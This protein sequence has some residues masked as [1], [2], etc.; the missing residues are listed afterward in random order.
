MLKVLNRNRKPGWD[1][2]PIEGYD[3]SQSAKLKLFRIV[4]LIWD[5]EL[6]S[7]E[8]VSGIF[9][10][11]YKQADRNNYANYRAI[12]LYC[13][14]YKL[15]NIVIAHR[16]QVPLEAILPDSQAG[17]R[18]AQGARDKVCISKWTINM[19]FINYVN[20]ARH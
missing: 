12:C 19:L 10:M 18:S 7:P 15:L 1:V 11:L 16:M 14:A 3:G 2:I 6:P 9:I 20:P 5:S 4:R 13:H 17:F 8:L